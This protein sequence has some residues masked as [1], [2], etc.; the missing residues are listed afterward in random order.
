[1]QDYM[2]FEELQRAIEAFKGKTDIRSKGVAMSEL[3]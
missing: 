1:M 2:A 3:T